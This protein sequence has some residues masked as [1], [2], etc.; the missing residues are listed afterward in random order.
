MVRFI[1]F[2]GVVVVSM[3]ESFPDYIAA[4]GTGLIGGFS[5]ICAWGVDGFIFLV[6][7]YRAFIPVLF[8]PLRPF[9]FVSMGDFSYISASVA[10]G[11]AR[12]RIIVSCLILGCAT[13]GA[14]VPMVICILRP[15]GT[16]M[17]RMAKA[18]VGENAI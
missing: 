11:I 16:V 13:A 6:T 12:I 18:D 8:R 10:I 3:T 14:S 17:M 2:H 1:V 15:R 7:A 4:D 5:S 9:R